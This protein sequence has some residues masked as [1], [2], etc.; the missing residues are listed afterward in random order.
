MQCAGQ[1]NCR[2]KR[3]PSEGIRLPAVEPE[4]AT[5]SNSPQSRPAMLSTAPGAASPRPPAPG[6]S[7]RQ[8]GSQF[9]PAPLPASRSVE[10]LDLGPLIRSKLL[11]AG[12]RTVEDLQHV[13]PARLVQGGHQRWRKAPRNA[14]TGRGNQRAPDHAGRG[15]VDRST[16]Q[17]RYAIT[18]RGLPS[19]GSLRQTALAAVSPDSVDLG[20]GSTGARS[21]K[22]TGHDV[23]L[24]D[25]Q[26]R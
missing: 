26:S 9:A 12:F 17:S 19:S 15:V 22:A 5:S 8:S 13:T 14:L 18:M 10:S 11:Q 1:L 6:T 23:L 21:A 2:F 4:S 24:R 25:G 7:Q 16:V 20:S 3:L